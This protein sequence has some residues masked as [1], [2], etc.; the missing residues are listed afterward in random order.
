MRVSFHRKLLLSVVFF[1]PSLGFGFDDWQPI[2]PEDL[3]LTSE[4]AGHADAIILYH[5]QISDDNKGHL[6]EYKRI[7]ILT[8]NG[9]RYA[10]VEIPYYGSDFQIVDVKART[11]SPDGTITPFSQKVY[12]KVAV[13]AHGLKVKVKSFTLPDVHAGSIIE[14]RYTRIWENKAL[15]AARWILQE[16]LLQRHAKFVFLPYRGSA[17]IETKRGDLANGVYWT[18]IGLPKGVEVKEAPDSS[19]QLEMRDIPAYEQEEFSP[20]PDSM[21]MRVQFYYGGRSMGKPVEFWKEEG[22]YWSKEVDKFIGHS[23]AIAEAAGTATTPSDSPEQKVRKIYDFVQKLKNSSYQEQSGLEGLTETSTSASSAEQVLKQ[24]AG[25]RDE[26]ARLF[27][28]MV[29]AVNIPVYMMRVGT[30]DETF[31]QPNIPDWR[32]LNSEIVIVHIAD[33]KD[34]FLDPGTRYC[35]FGML[36][37]TRTAVQG[38]RQT[39]GGGTELAKT[40]EPDYSQTVTQRIAQLKLQEDGS[41]TGQILFSWKGQE[42]LSRRIDASRT[43]EAGRTKALEDDLKAL[44]PSA[45]V[46]LASSKGWDNAEDRLQA[47]FNVDIPSFATVTGKRML[48]PCAL[49]GQREKQL[50]IHEQRKNPVYFPYPY[51]TFDSVQVT[52]PASLQ[53]ESLPKAQSVNVDFGVYTAERTVKGKALDL[54][55]DFAIGGFAFLVNHYPG[56]KSFYEKIKSGDEE[57]IVLQAAVASDKNK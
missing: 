20:P 9:K 53:V 43:D 48:L 32:Q 10:D 4:Q 34:V 47:V 21:K 12:D 3:K 18:P 35:P 38:V 1:L 19:I 11:I 5:Q 30:R 50:F 28:A 6:L 14:W 42:A 23:S 46:K 55:R 54:H 33:G 16:D 7:K 57:Q 45:T 22:K 41:L 51:R 27:V 56:L 2:T 37:W 17:E 36:E 44:L 26:I 40:P 49:F 39:Q 25:S 24:K 8:E 13:K 29:R 52:L 31:F 15:Y